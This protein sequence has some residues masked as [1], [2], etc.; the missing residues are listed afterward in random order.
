MRAS[1]A[2]QFADLVTVEHLPQSAHH[3]DTLVDKEKPSSAERT[4]VIS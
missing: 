3:S 4:A 1:L 2:L